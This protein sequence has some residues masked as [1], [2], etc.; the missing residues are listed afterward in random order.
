ME[1]KGLLVLSPLSPFLNNTVP[2]STAALRDNEER[3][4]GDTGWLSIHDL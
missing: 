2:M 4:F 1:L 3:R